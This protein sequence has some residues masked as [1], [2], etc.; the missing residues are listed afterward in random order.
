MDFPQVSEAVKVVSQPA[1]CFTATRLEINS[2][3][4][5]AW[6]RKEMK[7]APQGQPNVF[8]SPPFEIILL[9]YVRVAPFQL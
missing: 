6:V 3:G 9:G 8:L 4:L 7:F 2:P 1:V 5:Q